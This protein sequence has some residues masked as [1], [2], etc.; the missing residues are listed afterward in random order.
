M[1]RL[2]RARVDELIIDAG[3]GSARRG[4]G[5]LLSS[6]V[7]LTAADAYELLKNADAP[8]DLTGLILLAFERN[9]LANRGAAIPI[10]LPAV[11]A[12]LGNHARAMALA[13]S[14][15]ASDRQERALT[16]VATA[17]AAA[18]HPTDAHRLAVDAERI[19]RNITNDNQ[20]ARALTAVAAAGPT[21]AAEHI[22]VEALMNSTWVDAV[23]TLVLLVIIRNGEARLMKW[24]AAWLVA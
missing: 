24:L 10:D 15:T 21:D 18:G 3:L 7:V 12:S 23:A 22:G 11:W 4:S 16:A 2:Q 20:R 17:L 13:R 9:R 6:S 8:R 5:Y 1:A 14:I 19:A